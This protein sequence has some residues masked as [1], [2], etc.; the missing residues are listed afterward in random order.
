MLSTLLSCLF[1]WSVLWA[2][3][4]AAEESDAFEVARP[5]S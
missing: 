5:L 1:A 4:Q 3:A 2:F